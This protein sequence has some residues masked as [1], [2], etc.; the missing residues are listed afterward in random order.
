M[1]NRSTLSRRD[2]LLRLQAAGLTLPFAAKTDLYGSTAVPHSQIFQND[3]FSVIADT[4]SGRLNVIRRNGERL[5]TGSVV[6]ALTG[7]GFISTGQAAMRH[8]VDLSR[9]HDQLGD[10]LLITISSFESRKQISL[11]LRIFL[12]NSLQRRVF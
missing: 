6:R 7:N 12:Y 5:L 8:S 2:F 11:N 9:I 3:F 10:C 4:K 1:S